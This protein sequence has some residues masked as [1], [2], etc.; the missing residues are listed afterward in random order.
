M[1]RKRWFWMA[2]VLVLLLLFGFRAQ[3]REREDTVSQE[4]TA[5]KTSWT[6]TY[7]LN[8]GTNS[9]L[10]PEK[11]GMDTPLPARLYLPYRKG[12]NFSGWYAD[13]DYEQKV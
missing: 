13:A 5:E 12:Y 11:I 6:I 3:N 7:E 9:I 4:S 10:N 2:P 8:G 1:K